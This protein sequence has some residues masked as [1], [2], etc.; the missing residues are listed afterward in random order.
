MR[1]P[2]GGPGACIIGVRGNSAAWV[3]RSA[4]A[5]TNSSLVSASRFVAR[6]GDG[7]PCPHHPPL[8]GP[9][10]R[11]SKHESLSDGPRPADRCTGRKRSIAQR[12][13]GCQQRPGV[14]S[15]RRAGRHI[16]TKKARAFTGCLWDC[17]CEPCARGPIAGRPKPQGLAARRAPRGAICQANTQ[18]DFRRFRRISLDASADDVVRQEH[19]RARSPA[20]S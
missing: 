6:H 11:A 3:P 13:V 12:T 2:G 9:L 10:E 19:G 20:S 5:W 1:H 7:A 16:P 15:R 17:V 4:R 14:T 8:G 18:K